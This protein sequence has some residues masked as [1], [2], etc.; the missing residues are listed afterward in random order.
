MS[1]IGPHPKHIAGIQPPTP[2]SSSYLAL[3]PNPSHPRARSGSSGSATSDTSDTLKFISLDGSKVHLPG[4]KTAG[5][6]FKTLWQHIPEKLSKFSEDVSDMA[7][8]IKGDTL[9]LSKTA[10]REIGKGSKGMCSEC[11]KM[12]LEH[13]IPGSNQR[14]GASTHEYIRPLERI[15]LQ[16]DMCLFCNVLYHALCKDENDPLKTEHIQDHIQGQL[17]GKSFKEWTENAQLWRRIF[18]SNSVWPFGHSRDTADD[19]EDIQRLISSTMPKGPRSLDGAPEAALV[20][21]LAGLKGAKIGGG[22]KISKRDRDIIEMADA[23]IPLPCWVL[24]KLHTEE[25]SKSGLLVV[26]VVARN[27]EPRSALKEISRFHLRVASAPKYP[28]PGIPLRYGNKLSEYVDLRLAR[29]WMEVCTDQHTGFVN[30]EG[31]C[32]EDC[33]PGSGVVPYAALSYR[34]LNKYYTPGGLRPEIAKQAGLQYLWV[35]AL[36]IQQ[37]NA[38]DSEAQIG[39]MDRIYRNALLTI[40]AADGQ[41]ANSPFI[42]VSGPRQAH[43]FVAEQIRPNVNIL[44]PVLGSTNLEP[45]ET[46]AWTLQEKMLSNRL[47]VFSGGHMMWHC[48]EAV[49]YEDMTATDA[50]TTLGKD[51]ASPLLSSGLREGD[52]PNTAV[53]IVSPRDGTV[54]VTRSAAFEK[55]MSYSSDVLRALSGI[56]PLLNKAYGL[57]QTMIDIAIL[58]Q[59][60]GPFRRRKHCENSECNEPYMPSWSWAGWEGDVVYEPSFALIQK[61]GPERIRPIVHFYAKGN[62]KLS[63]WTEPSRCSSSKSSTIVPTSPKPRSIPPPKPHKKLYLSSSEPLHVPRSNTTDPAITPAVNKPVF[64]GNKL[65]RIGLL[66]SM[67]DGDSGALLWNNDRPHMLQVGALPWQWEA[68]STSFPRQLTSRDAMNT[69]KQHLI[70]HTQ[71]AKIHLG[72][73]YALEISQKNQERPKETVSDSSDTVLRKIR[74][75]SHTAPCL[76]DPTW[77][78]TGETR[79]TQ[80]RD[81][82][83]KEV[84]RVQI[85]D[86]SAQGSWPFD[87]IVLSEAQY[88]GDDS[89]VDVADFPLYNVMMVSKPGGPSKVRCRMGLGKVYK[90]AWRMAGAVDELV[91]LG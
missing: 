30:L 13:C 52:P 81:G 42:G 17:K 40:V 59:P 72:D 11:A 70:F 5:T 4:L 21:G 18:K 31:Y 16:R 9:D 84:G 34:T 2:K 10:I 1:T 77:T 35:D 53:F 69:G 55:K 50:K 32:L 28:A 60:S 20:A 67:E 80:I 33:A 88:F 45:W 86:S 49:H 82:S 90:Y 51:R 64:Q 83:G 43:Q 7:I 78:I 6:A 41:N 54:S 3:P 37:D 63:E 44:M 12:K 39:Q 61:N 22:S 85:H 79:A 47:L 46:R 27:R 36:C 68:S 73:N 19:D 66:A 56:L 91:V 57:P 48:H 23:T 58:W 75:K 14:I 62:Q 65:Q 38:I 87:F 74:Q 8:E 15:I 24:I 29:L 71:V 89:V 26:H 76:A 25:S